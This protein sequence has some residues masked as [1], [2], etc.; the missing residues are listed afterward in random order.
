MPALEAA[1]E[2]ACP[3]QALEIARLRIQSGPS[4]VTSAMQ[5]LNAHQDAMGIALRQSA[6]LRTMGQRRRGHRSSR[7]GFHVLSNGRQ[8]GYPE[9]GGAASRAL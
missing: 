3:S 8:L 6:R 2:G 7:F 1:F 5:G 4:L 9:C